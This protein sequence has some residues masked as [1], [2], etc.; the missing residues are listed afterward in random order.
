[1][2]K[3]NVCLNGTKLL[4]LALAVCLSSPEIHTRAVTDQ[5]KTVRTGCSDTATNNYNNSDNPTVEGTSVSL[6]A[7]RLISC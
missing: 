7:T 6:S 1:M 3:R 2:L 5:K 4:V